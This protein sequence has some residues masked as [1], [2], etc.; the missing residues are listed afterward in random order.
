MPNEGLEGLFE[1]LEIFEGLSPEQRHAIAGRFTAMTVRR[2]DVLMRQGEAAQDMFIVVSGRFAVTLD[3]RKDTISEIGPGQPIGEIAFLAGGTRTATVTALRDSLVLK[4]TRQDFE[5]LTA[6][7]PSLWRVITVALAR[8]IADLNAARPAPPDPR[9][10]TIAIVRAGATPFPKA[11]VTALAEALSRP[12]QKRKQRDRRVQVVDGERARSLL[13]NGATFDS[14]S[15]THAINDLE[16]QSEFVIYVADDELT[17]WSEKAIRQSDVVLAVG[18]HAGDAQPNTLER[19]AAELLPTSARRLVLLHD[20]RGTITGTSRWLHGRDIAMHH[21]VALDEPGDLARL[22]RFLKGTA[23][24]LIA[25]GGGALC[26]A[27][28]GLF[29]AFSQAGITF[30]MMGGTSGGSAYTAAFALGRSAEE[31]EA[32]THQMFVE[33][34]AMRRLT[35]PRYSLIDHKHFDAQLQR[36]YGGFEIEDMWIPYFAISTNLSRNALHRHAAGSLWTAVRASAAIP[37]VLPPYY[38]R[39]GD[40]L[41]DGCLLDNVPIRAM[42]ELKSGPNVVM[43]FAVPDMERFDVSY[44]ELPSRAA[45][46]SRVVNPFGRKTLPSAPGLMT[47][48]LRSLMANRQD[49][50]RHLAEEDLLVI[51]PVPEDMSFLDWPRHAELVEMAYAWAMAELAREGAPLHAWLDS[52]SMEPTSTAT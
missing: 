14:D 46:L 38:T 45:L 39:N 5:Q 17:A 8:R 28:I 41:V 6:A 32:A 47:V 16:R 22:S 2:A 37:V 43:S 19:R 31:I 40:M 23:I 35:W 33:N 36:H 12:S 21:H 50:K 24:G 49:F 7:S 25:C 18:M 29:K 30:D 13:F 20:T 4:L 27:Q 34:R 10:R 26:T 1:K 44:D 52:V 48:L 15:A 3:G 11:F 42:H 51:P 9:P